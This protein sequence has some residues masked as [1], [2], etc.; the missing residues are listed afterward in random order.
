[1]PSEAGLNIHLV[2]ENDSVQKIII[3]R[4][5]SQDRY[6]NLL[7]LPNSKTVYCTAP[8]EYYGSVELIVESETNRVTATIKAVKDKS[9]GLFQNRHSVASIYKVTGF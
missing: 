2:N 9:S 5:N 1:M 6:V 8:S 3:H 4:A 7:L